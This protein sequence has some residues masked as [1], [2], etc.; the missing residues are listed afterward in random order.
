MKI[1]IKQLPYEKVLSLPRPVHHPPRRPWWILRKVIRL[2]SLPDLWKTHFTFEK[3]RMDEI[4]HGPWLVLMNHSSFIDLE[5]AHKLLARRPFCIVATSDG[6]IGK[7]WLMR[8]IGCIPTRKFVTSPE[9]IDDMRHALGKLKCSVL[10]FPEASY[11]F[12]G[13]ATPLPRRLGILL[14]R[15]NVPVVSI[16][17]SGA[18]TLNPLYNNLQ[19]RKVRVSATMRGLLT[20]DEILSKSVQEL[21]DILDEAFSFDH[22]AWQKENSIHIDEPFRADGLHRIL[23][24]CAACGTEGKTEGKG[25]TLTCHACGK[26]YQLTTLGEL[27]AENGKTEFTHIPHWYEWQ[28]REVRRELEEN[29]YELDIPVDIAMMADYKAIYKVGS[30]RLQHGKNGFVLDGCDGKLHYTQPPLASYG[31]YSDYYWYELG[32]IICI[33]NQEYLYYCFPKDGTAV[34]K[35]RLAAEELYKMSLAARRKAAAGTVT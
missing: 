15:L 34:A 35:T 22:F 20:K 1:R 3:H 9:L 27:Q 5:I 17:T 29:R 6:F 13:R 31:L 32:D 28:R 11:S 24:K 4:G 10:L 25:T 26:R 30:G 16:T 8:S 12:D 21:D 2:V 7:E 33:G 19:K 18:F 14:K 23:Y